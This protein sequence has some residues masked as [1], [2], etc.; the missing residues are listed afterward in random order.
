MKLREYLKITH[1]INPLKLFIPFD[2]QM[3]LLKSMKKYLLMLTSNRLGK[4]DWLTYDLSLYATGQ[5]PYHKTPRNAV[6]WISVENNDKI[7]QVLYPKFRDRLGP[8]GS[9]WEYNENKKTIYVRCGTNNWSEIVFKSE[10][11]ER[12]SKGTYEGSK[13]HRLGFDEVPSEDIF[14][15]AIIRTIDTKAQILVAATTWEET[16]FW[17]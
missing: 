14:N 7:P 11:A 9:R 3:V 16:M 5:H 17:L 13:I 15:K 10:Q 12:L 1:A 4:S 2:Y 8:Q 6:T